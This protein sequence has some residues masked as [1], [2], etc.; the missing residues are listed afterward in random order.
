ME[1]VALNGV[2]QGAGESIVLLHPIG[3]DHSFW[4]GLPARLAR[5]RRVLALDLR[6]FGASPPGSGR[7]P[8]ATYAADV[9]DAMRRHGI[10]CADVLGLSFGGL[11]AQML[12]LEHPQTVSRLVLCGCTGGIPPEARDILRER[13]LAAERG[14][15]EAIVPATIERWFTP[16]FVGDPVVERVRER[17]R[18][19]SV[20]AWSDGWHAIAEFNALPRLGAVAVPTLVVAGEVDAA[21]SAAA[22]R[23]LAGAIA[24]ARL[25]TLAGAPHMMQLE[26]GEVFAATVEEFLAA[27]V[28]R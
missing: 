25:V 13:G 5:V 15:M 23:A 18:S 4:G 22:A 2:A 27:P 28:A 26:A 20:A 14:G 8:M 7:A 1:T 16:A 6:G 10:E 9:A 12:A 11:V 19:D 3:L 21:N 24:G 17:L